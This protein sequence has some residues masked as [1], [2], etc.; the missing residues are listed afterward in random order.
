MASSATQDWKT[1]ATKHRASLDAQIPEEWR[2]TAEFKA[3][4]PADGRLLQADSIRKSGILT[5]A[6]LDITG[7]Y[8]A[9]QLLQ[10]LAWGDV[11]SVDVT[12]AFCKRA[13]VAG[14]LTNCLTEHFFSRALKRA[15]YLDEYLKREGKVAGPLH[16]LPISLK[17]SFC[18]EGIPTTVGYVSF[19]KNGPA[20][21]NSALVNLLLDLG[22]VLYVKTNIPQTMMTADS[23]NAIYGRT[24]NPHNT[25]LTAGG[26]TGGEGALQAL[27]GSILGV[28]TDIAGSIRIPALCC[29]VYGFKP[30]S[31]RVP[32][33]G[34][35]SGYMA[36]IPGI[37]GCA[38]PLGQSID[39]IELFMATVLSGETWRYD[40]T[41]L[42]AP[43]ASN[44]PANKSVEGRLLTI[45][46]LPEDPQ[47]PLHPPVRR[48]LTSA[49]ESLEKKGHRLV[50]LPPT[51][52]D[53]NTSTAYASR[54]AWQYFTYSP[55]I[56]HMA[57]SG[58]PPIASVAKGASPLFTGELPISEEDVFK[59]ISALHLA[60]KDYSDFWRRTWTEYGLDVVLAP[61]AQNTAVPHDTYAWPPY[62]AM[63][64]LVDY[65]AIIIPYGK[66]S[67]EL[68]SETVVS[69][70]KVQP[71]YNPEVVNGAPCALQVV[72]PRFQ[73]EKCLSAARIIDQDIRL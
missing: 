58:E 2:L 28:G 23:E 61:G 16:G 72:A 29:G 37:E 3:S 34:Q 11:S 49:I 17:D 40:S 15:Q 7:K 6:E 57:P 31:N 59:K 67:A 56:D 73:D 47:Y 60:K 24:L 8:S 54:L 21:E 5:E 30:T 14:Q 45:G 66:A 10:R 41:S 19:L 26:S 55:F 52:A 69:K 38:G 70:D 13:A 4:L 25:A 35:I 65:P 39:D 36:G 22:A 53:S 44:I 42:S 62:T 12:R 1:L 68:D 71:S 46:I 43:W 27:R 48:A 20:R 32:F 50:Q 18:L 64:N 33:G 51:L 9:A 63:W